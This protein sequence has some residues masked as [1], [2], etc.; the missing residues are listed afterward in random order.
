MKKI[1]STSLE[2]P[3][4]HLELYSNCILKPTVYQLDKV[5]NPWITRR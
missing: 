1:L 2:I 4:N 5:D 3:R